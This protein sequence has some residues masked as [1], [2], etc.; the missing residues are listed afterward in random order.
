MVSHKDLGDQVAMPGAY[1]SA[2]PDDV[3]NVMRPPR[4]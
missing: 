4:A 3:D 1:P 2:H